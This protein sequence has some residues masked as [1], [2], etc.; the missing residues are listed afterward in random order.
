MMCLPVPKSADQGLVSGV[1]SILTV[2]WYSGLVA[3]IESSARTPYKLKEL[4]RMI[5]TTRYRADIHADGIAALCQ[6]DLTCQDLKDIWSKIVVP[7][8]I[9]PGDS[10]SI[11]EIQYFGGE[12]QQSPKYEILDF[13]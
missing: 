8:L 12:I 4:V 7:I 13:L 6:L 1:N 2:L 10:I 3:Y 11:D 9:E 5:K